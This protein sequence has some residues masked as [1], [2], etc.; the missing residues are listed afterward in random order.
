[1]TLQGL[2]LDLNG[3]PA[4]GLAVKADG[5]EWFKGRQR[6]RVERIAAAFRVPAG[7]RI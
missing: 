1:M 2:Y 4:S 6:E 3:K 5:L 7:E